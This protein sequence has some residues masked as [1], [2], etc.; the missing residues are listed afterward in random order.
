MSRE[1]QSLA[2]KVSIESLVEEVMEGLA[3]H[4]ATKAQERAIASGVRHAAQRAWRK[5]VNV[6]MQTAVSELVAR[7]EALLLDEEQAYG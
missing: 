2:A 1:T 5:G 3:D 4:I 7:R 6:G